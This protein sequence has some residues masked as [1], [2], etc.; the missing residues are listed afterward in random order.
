MDRMSEKT[1][2]AGEHTPG[3]WTLG[4][5]H[6]DSGR[7]LVGSPEDYICEICGLPGEPIPEA[8]ARLIAKA[9]KMLELF[10]RLA[11]HE[12]VWRD[13]A[14]YKSV[15]NVLGDL[16]VDTYNFIKDLEAKRE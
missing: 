13:H 16:A 9:P 7:I 2:R 4:E 10:K 15:T 14:Q 6:V 8:N 5:V 12:K 11:K 1:N 3:P